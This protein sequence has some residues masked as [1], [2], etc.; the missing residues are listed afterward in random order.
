[1]PRAVTTVGIHQQVRVDGDQ[2]PRLS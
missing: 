2:S 1:V